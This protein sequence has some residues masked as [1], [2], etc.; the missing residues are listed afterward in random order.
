MANEAYSVVTRKG[1]I[2]LPAEI[3]RALDIQEGDK[4]AVSLAEREQMTIIVRPVR[5]VAEATFGAVEPLDRPADL[6]MLRRAFEE[7]L[8]E[9]VESGSSARDASQ[10]PA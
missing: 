4:V 10:E 2:T 8:A 7:G 6:D 5:S 9:E 1:Q 3:R